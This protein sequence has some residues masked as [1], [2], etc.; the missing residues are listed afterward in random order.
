MVATTNDNA[1]HQKVLD[2]I[3]DIRVAL[4][5]TSDAGGHLRGRPMSA[6]SRPSDARAFD[7]VLWFASRESTAKLDEIAQ[8]PN[9]LLAYS[10]PKDQNYVSVSGTAQVVRD[11]AKV[12]ELWSEPARVWFPKG[13][14]DPDIALIR[15]EIESAEYWDAPSSAWVYAIGYAKARLTGEAP[16]NVGDNKIVNF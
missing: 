11:P 1:G 5:V 16:K 3:K 10:E 13:P 15:V 14:D 8:H 9:V 12:R 6:M 7:G 2:L 4:L